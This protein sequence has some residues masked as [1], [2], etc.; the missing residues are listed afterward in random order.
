MILSCWKGSS[1][2]VPNSFFGCEKVVLLPWAYC[3]KEVVDNELAS[4]FCSS[5]LCEISLENISKS[6]K[7][8]GVKAQS[9][10]CLDNLTWIEAG[11]L[12]DFHCITKGVILPGGDAEQ[13]VSLYC[14]A[15]KELP[16]HHEIKSNPGRLDNNSM[17]YPPLFTCIA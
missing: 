3:P 14:A 4:L 7:G 1:Y 5:S 6:K 13:D 9:E 12:F 16:F 8:H 11:L 2:A 15:Q 10:Q 17:I